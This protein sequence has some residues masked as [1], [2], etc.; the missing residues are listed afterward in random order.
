M[1][2]SNVCLVLIGFS[3]LKRGCVFGS[4]TLCSCETENLRRKETEVLLGY[5]TSSLVT[6]R[7]SVG[8]RVSGCSKFTRYFNQLQQFKHDSVQILNDNHEQHTSIRD[9]ITKQRE[10][11]LHRKRTCSFSNK[12]T[13]NVY[14]YL[15]KAYT[16]NR[17]PRS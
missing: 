14:I 12:C 7:R 15:L 17:T 8:L 3:V 2:D 1:F 11:C 13:V 6:S 16:K 9:T 5:Q 4:D 10:L